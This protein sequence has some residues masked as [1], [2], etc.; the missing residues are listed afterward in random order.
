M[1][2]QEQKKK[3]KPPAMLKVP[4]DYKTTVPALSSSS[5]GLPQGAE[6]S[7]TPVR[8]STL[9]NE[10]FCRSV[11]NSWVKTFSEEWFDFFKIAH[12]LE[13]DATVKIMQDSLR[14][15]SLI[16]LGAGSNF[17]QAG[18]RL[19]EF[20]ECRSYTAVDKH[21]R[22]VAPFP[23]EPTSVTLHCDDMLTFTAGLAP[24]D[25]NFTLNGIDSLVIANDHYHYALAA[26]ISRACRPGSLVFGVC[27]E[28]FDY[29]KPEKWYDL[30]PYWP[31]NLDYVRVFIKK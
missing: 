1:T 25:H 20:F 14:G 27:S 22:P 18:Y 21:N 19:A 16:D 31:E 8:Y 12:Y 11:G 26:E 24:G 3:Y 29:F 17:M 15:G 23:T 6:F 4:A 7:P 9:I 5:F 2:Q 30:S 28:V 10:T 13:H